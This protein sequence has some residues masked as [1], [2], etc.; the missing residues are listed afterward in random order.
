MLKGGGVGGDTWEGTLSEM[1]G[2]R[3]GKELCKEG[4]RG[5][6]IWDVNK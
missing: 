6:S 3:H 1:K 5:G 4:P 2:R